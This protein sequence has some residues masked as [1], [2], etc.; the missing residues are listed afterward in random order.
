MRHVG[1]FVGAIL[2]VSSS[3]LLA[4]RPGWE[5]V[6]EH[7]VARD[8]HHAEISARPIVYASHLR[9]CADRQAVRFD[10]LDVLYR[11]GNRQSVPIRS[12]VPAGRCTTDIGLSNRGERDVDRIALDLG[13]D[14][15]GVTRPR[16]L[17]FARAGLVLR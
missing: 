6:G 1:S 16:I 11:N 9:L 7:T 13:A 10:R 8:T 12:V 17:I 14:A 4:G 15:S 2:L 3:H 5:L